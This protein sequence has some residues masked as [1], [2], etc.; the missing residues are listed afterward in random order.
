M[1]GRSNG[2][3]PVKALAYISGVQL[4]DNR[5]G[6]TWDFKEKS[7]EE[8]QILLP[9]NAPAWAKEI[10]KL[11]SEDRENGLQLLSDIA[12]KAEKRS[13]A[14]VYREVEFSLPRELTYEQN[15]KLATEYVQDQ[16][17]Q[18]GMLAIQG[19]HT[20]V[21]EKTGELNP[22]CHTFFL[23][24]ELTEEGLSLKKNREWN[25]R[26]LHGQWR[27]Q[28]AQYASF[29]LKMNGHDIALDHRSYKDQGLDIEPQVKLGKGVKEQE[30]RGKGKGDFAK[31]E[32]G[33]G[34]ESGLGLDKG[35]NEETQKNAESLDSSQDFSSFGQGFVDAKP[36]TERVQSFREVQ[37]RN[38]YRIVRR[39]ETVFDIVTRHHATFMWGDVQKKLHQYVDNTELFQR[40]DARL[41][42][43]KELILLKMEG[44]QDSEGRIEERAI[45]TTRSMLKAERELV[46]TA[47]GLAGVKTHAVSSSSLECGIERMQKRL[48]K[49]GFNLSEGQDK[50]IR[51][52]VEEGQLK[53]MVGYAGAGKTTALEA[54]RDIWETEGYRVYGL[55]PTGKAAQNLEGSGIS[56]QTL[57]KFLKS[58]EEG[59]SQYSDKSIL[60]LDEAG[61]VDVERFEKFLGAVKALGVKAVVVG[62]GAQLQPV[63]A[64]PA[65]RLVTERVGVSRLEEIVRQKEI[66]QKEA[67][68]LFG[69]QESQKAIQA[70]QE[71][72]Y[73]HLIE[74]KL[75][76]KDKAEDIV[77]RYEMAARTLGLI[78]REIMKDIKTQYPEETNSSPHIRNHEDYSQFLK[79]R[80]V[81][82]DS[83]K[84]IL[85]QPDVYK[86]ILEDRNL[87]PLEMARLFVNRKQ[88]KSA[89]Y[90]EATTLL[91]TKGL[92]HL[93]G[94]ERASGQSFGHTVD[95][96]RGAKATLI[97]DWKKAYQEFPD[98]SLLMMAY[99]NRDVRDLNT[100][101]REH[102]KASGVIEKQE[103]TYTITREVEDD[104][105]RK[106]R[107]KEERSF[108]KGDRLVFTRNRKSLDVKNGSIG[109]IA[110][111]DKNT[112]EVKLDEGKTVKFTPHLFSFFDQG[113][114]VTIHKSQGETADKSMLLVSHEMN[115]NLTYV[116]MTRHREDVHVYG[117]SLDFW[118]E[119]K[120]SEILSK[121]GEK[122]GAA[123]YLDA[124]SLAKLMEEEDR[125]L[126]KLFT[127]LGDELQAMGAVSKRAF[128]AVV[129][130]FLGRSSGG[131]LERDILLKLETLRE[132]V[133]AQ[134]ILQKASDPP[135]LEKVKP[136][137]YGAVNEVHSG[138]GQSLEFQHIMVNPTLQDIY[139]DMRHPAFK[140]ADKYKQV[141]T[142]G[143]E[144]HG[145]ER[146][147]QYW[148]SKRELFLKLY[149]KK[150][151]A[152]EKELQSPLLSYLSDES[153][154]LTRK[155][156]HEDPDKVLSRLASLQ[157]T[158]KAEFEE[159]TLEKEKSESLSLQGQ[160]SL[161]V[162][163]SHKGSPLNQEK[164]SSR[165]ESFDGLVQFCEDRLRSLLDKDNVPL[166]LERKQR[167]PLQAE[168]TA[169]FLLHRYGLEKAEVQEQEMAQL[170]LRAKYELKRIPEIRR[171]LIKEW[172]REGNFD[173]DKDGIF[174]HM[175][176]D[177]LA[178]IEGRLYLEAKQRGLNPPSNIEELAQKE[179]ETHRQQTKELAA[180]IFQKYFLSE[181]A[182]LECAKN[183]LRY[184]E[185]HGEKP[186]KDQ[187]SHIILVEK[188][189]E[190]NEARYVAQGFKPHEIAFLKRTEAD[191][192][193]RSLEHTKISNEMKPSNEIEQSHTRARA[194]LNRAVS[195][196][197]QDISRLH[198]KGLSL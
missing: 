102:L 49:K 36:T 73:V 23:T 113:W 32:E 163:V 52:L 148:Q 169:T 83:G 189:L 21:C 59:R 22:H 142:Q 194:S 121:S 48:E 164:V 128:N 71:R 84:K 172:D 157:A 14:Q 177:R 119:E 8:I 45:Y 90:K 27:E 191:R 111:L 57:H 197:E 51:H 156:A 196:I 79:W 5:T 195:Q 154:T 160:P 185:T 127:R 15:K 136:E 178:S 193:F 60:V 109:K 40:L 19:F 39:P 183:V 28:W 147:I 62:D 198:Q 170:S 58:F 120:V 11:V 37:L 180:E 144:L 55:A 29:Y 117:S 130:H 166:T 88:D 74:E 174:A 47:E 78:F 186:S 187:I 123:D 77:M 155:A 2:G 9:E 31:T 56:S 65:F 140:L 46:K 18:R 152:V 69:R 17:C 159:A 118:R 64:G 54:C 20:E 1:I 110:S 124:Q 70:Y 34:S 125:F 173:E 131:D 126:G 103:F 182:S 107:L 122:L 10:Q 101:A 89:Q 6:E 68:V 106:I 93:I 116:G 158:K 150:L 129:D 82:K 61:M 135:N 105:G 97:E 165:W 184:K 41:R 42:S 139:E 38:L 7:V 67:T 24:R 43:S 96:R 12:N 115:Q 85:G 86:P 25:E 13:D 171:K 190:K 76:G 92:E 75:P 87:D 91:K 44:I 168:R 141:F 161:E 179:I 114:A 143:L 146:A 4:T 100:Q 80:E 145:E 99:S 63:E 72:G 95:V 50:A 26:D 104:F 108:S 167:I 181:K 112:I 188:T 134:E 138:R 94:S 81:Q 16:F 66:W 35:T 192:L 149:E 132:E 162:S 133:R 176:A 153:R 3:S 175:I 151:T 30:K 137:Y 53:C 98:K 33:L